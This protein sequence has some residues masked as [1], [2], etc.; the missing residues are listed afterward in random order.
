M[1]CQVATAAA[2]HPFII[3]PVCIATFAAWT[4]SG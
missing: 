2:H 4:G 3:A 1:R